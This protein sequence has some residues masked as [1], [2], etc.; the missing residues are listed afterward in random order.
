MALT[1]YSSNTAAQGIR[2]AEIAKF[3]G[4]NVDPYVGFVTVMVYREFG[5]KNSIIF[6]W[7]DETFDTLQRAHTVWGGGP[8]RGI[9]HYYGL[10]Q[11]D[12]SGFYLVGFA[13]S[14]LVDY[15]TNI[16]NSGQKGLDFRDTLRIWPV[17]HPFEYD[18]G[19]TSSRQTSIHVDSSGAVLHGLPYTIDIMHFGLDF[20]TEEIVAFPSEG[21]TYPEATDS[22]Y[23]Y[24]HILVWDR[25]VAPGTYAIGIKINRFRYDPI[26][27][28]DTVY[29]GSTLRAMMIDVSEEM[30]VSAPEQWV[31]GLV[32]VYPN[33]AT[34]LLHLQLGGF[35]APVQVRIFDALG[36]QVYE[37]QADAAAQVET[38]RIPV[39]TWPP[40]VYSVQLTSGGKV[41]TRQVVVQR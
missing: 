27:I 26:W 25:P 22:I 13:D 31:D 11:Y 8:G 33:P 23:I 17:G 34:D 19:Y 15:V 36:R 3:M 14:F 38:L 2:G 20:F 40:G 18:R 7:G 5:P 16:E 6:D 12:T 10:H 30:I 29:I 39:A 28:P 1:V 32:S 35:H 4:S 24:D 21:Y 37:T 41:L 9:D